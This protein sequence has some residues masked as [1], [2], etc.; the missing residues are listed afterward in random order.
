MNNVLHAG[1]NARF[2]TEAIAYLTSSA[3]VLPDLDLLDEDKELILS[4]YVRGLNIIII[5]FAVL[6]VIMLLASLCLRDYGL[7]QGRLPE[8]NSDPDSYEE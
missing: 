2:S 4:L 5:S 8:V 1:L 3:L 7:S 6:I